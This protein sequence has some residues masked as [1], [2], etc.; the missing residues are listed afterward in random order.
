MAIDYKSDLVERIK[1]IK[2]LIMDIDGVLT[3]GRVGYDNSGNEIKFFNVQDG[4]ALK[5]AKR[6]NLITGAI[7]GRQAA[8]NQRR[9]TEL[10]F[11]FLYERQ[12]DKRVAFEK[13]LDEFNVT[14][15]ECAYIGDDVIDI[16]ILRQVGLAVAVNNAPVELDDFVNYRTNL[17]GGHGAVRELIVM[18]LKGQNSWNKLM[19]RY[20]K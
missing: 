12:L 1:K 17:C 3:D 2:V 5:M 7:S 4:H 8:A 6:G 10:D 16:P 9:A 20:V 13:V 11:D 19:E 15:E 14:A 18:I